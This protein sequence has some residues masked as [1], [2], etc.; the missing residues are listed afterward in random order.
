MKVLRKKH[1]IESSTKVKCTIFAFVLHSNST[2]SYKY[3]YILCERIS[4]KKGEDRYLSRYRPNWKSII[5]MSPSFEWQTTSSHPVRADEL[6]HPFSVLYL[7]ITFFPLL[8]KSLR[9]FIEHIAM[10]KMCHVFKWCNVDWI[11]KHT[12]RDAFNLPPTQKKKTKNTRDHGT[13]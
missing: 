7:R 9:G 1:K 5:N 6:H 11:N 2:P 8:K 4:D 12:T 10:N 13:H 3:V